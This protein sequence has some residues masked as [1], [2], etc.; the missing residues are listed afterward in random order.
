MK[1]LH[2]SEHTSRKSKVKRDLPYTFQSTVFLFVGPWHVAKRFFCCSA[3][4]RNA[5]LDFC[6]VT[7]KIGARGEWE[8]YSWT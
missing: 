5:N 2:Y 7:V 8:I 4:A 3:A 1:M 6:M